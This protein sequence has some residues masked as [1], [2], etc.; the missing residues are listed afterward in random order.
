MKK[1]NPVRTVRDVF[2]SACEINSS[3][4]RKAYLDQACAK[5]PEIRQ[6][7][8]ALLQAYDAA[9]SRFLE[10]P[11]VPPFTTGPNQ[12]A[13]DTPGSSPGEIQKTVDHEGRANY[14]VVHEGPGTQIGPYKLIKP[15]GEGG[16][17]VVWLAEQAQPIRRQ[18]ALKII[19]SGMVNSA[20]V[21]ARFKAERQALTMMEHVNIA[22]VLDAGATERGLPYFVME[23]VNGVPLTQFCNENTLTPRERLM[24]FIT[25]CQAIQHAHQKGIIHRDI[26]PSNVLVALDNGTPMAKV[27]DFGLAK[28]TDQTLVEEAGVT[29]FGSVVGTYSYMSPEQADVGNPGIDTRTDIYSLGVMLYELL[30]GTTPLACAKK[31]TDQPHDLLRKIKEEEPPRPS[32]LVAGLG[33]RLP[34]IAA[35]RNTEPARLVKL[36][37]GELDWIT[38]K[39]L[40]KDRKRRYDTASGFAA[41]VQ[42]YLDD[43]RVEA[44]PPSARYLLGKFARKHRTLLGVAAGFV[45]LLVLGVV[46]LTVGIVEVNDARQREES[47]KLK[48][49]KARKATAEALRVSDAV[50]QVVG[51]DLSRLGEREKKVLL[52]LLQNSRRSLPEPGDTQE[53]RETAAEAQRSLAHNFAFIGEL[54]E[55]VAGYGRAIQ[56]YS[57]LEADYPQV[58][59]YREALARTYF[60]MAIRLHKLDKPQEAEAAYE[61]AI[62]LH[63]RLTEER[64]DEVVFRRDLADDYNNLG[65]LLRDQKQLPR[66]EK[67]FRQAMTLGEKLVLDDPDHRVNLGGNYHNLGNAVRDQGNPTASLEWYSKAIQT[68]AAIDPPSADVN[69]VLRNACWDRANALGQLGR[70]AQASQDW[71]RAVALEGEGLAQGHLRHFL[72]AS[73]I[74]GKLN[75][76]LK[77]AGSLLYEAAVV[78]ALAT[79]AAGTAEE[80]GLQN[81]YSKRALALLTQAK[82]AGW[83][84]DPQRIT[85]LKADRSF[86]ALPDADFKAFLES[87]GTGRDPNDRPE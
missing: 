60:D 13:G 31:P 57:A 15:L 64:S 35:K 59:E 45:A 56:L 41:D 53:S 18:V 22:R 87:L 54:Q 52:I 58:T 70:H 44:C 12:P 68:L 27:I 2:D 69:L 72:A 30:T 28:A 4:E 50:V 63:T 80:P 37:R 74:E 81:Q 19:R 32:A 29:V 8:E 67:A 65:A 55:A 26:K 46:G 17:G 16:M 23:F 48:A 10:K 5:A 61:R 9:G 86:G 33:E 66:A 71:Q 38:L 83:F 40:E 11:A 84:R 39:A 78:H 75:A 73:Q 82:T 79:V 51:R 6:Q 77:P 14:E 21:V 85:Q 42:R 25:I 3:G 1:E 34:K 36:L 20:H 49:V 76:Q 24:L 62:A 47:Q 7:V 43:E